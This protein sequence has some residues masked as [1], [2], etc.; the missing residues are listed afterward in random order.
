MP[1][2]VCSLVRTPLFLEGSLWAGFKSRLFL[3]LAVH[4]ALA[5]YTLRASVSIREVGMMTEPVSWSL[6]VS[7]AAIQRATDKVA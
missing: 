5:A 3:S 6:L 4:L 7:G 1:S 2:D